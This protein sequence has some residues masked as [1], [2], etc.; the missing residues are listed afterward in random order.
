MSFI[1]HES[2][3]CRKLFWYEC[4][5]SINREAQGN[6]EMNQLTQIEKKVEILYKKFKSKE[7]KSN[8]DYVDKCACALLFL[9]AREIIGLLLP[10][11]GSLSKP[12][13]RRQWERHKTKELVS[14]T[15]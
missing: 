13:R 8:L 12:P 4:F 3:P 1:L 10:T 9:I 5:G 6:W 14:K 15:I 11:L 7:R 2:E